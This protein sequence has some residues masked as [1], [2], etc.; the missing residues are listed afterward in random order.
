MK[1]KLKKFVKYF[2]YIVYYIMRLKRVP[3][4]IYN[5]ITYHIYIY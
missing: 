4:N 5:I 2:E 3:G 1:Y